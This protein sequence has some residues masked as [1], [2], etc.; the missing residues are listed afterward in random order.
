M[1]VMQCRSSGIS[2]GE[3]RISYVVNA[4]PR[5]DPNWAD[6]GTSQGLEY[7]NPER[8]RRDAKMYTIFFDHFAEHGWWRDRSQGVVCRTRV[9]VDSIASMDGTS[10]TILLSEN[11]DAGRWIWHDASSNIV[12]QSHLPVTSGHLG[13]ASMDTRPADNLAEVESIVGFCYPNILSSIA[14]RRNTNIRTGNGG[15]TA[16]QRGFAIVYQ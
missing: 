4:G 10:M 9:S 12:G 7:G 5:N 1:P 6:D 3:S 13:A 8:P 16:Q 14:D 15:W 2:S 11:E